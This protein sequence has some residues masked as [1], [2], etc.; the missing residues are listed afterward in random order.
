MEKLRLPNWH[1]NDNGLT[2][3]EVLAAVSLLSVILFLAFSIH[4]FGQNQWNREAESVQKDANVR[5]AMTIVTKAIRSAKTVEVTDNRALVINGTDRYAV[6]NGALTKN[7]SILVP[8]IGDFVIRNDGDKI[9]LEISDSVYQKKHALE[10][11][12]YLRE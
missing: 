4:L 9:H 5:L 2:L 7:Q 8:D 11:V 6:S 10:T 12:I 3:I 1:K